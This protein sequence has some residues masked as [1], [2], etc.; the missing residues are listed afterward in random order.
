[1]EGVKNYRGKEEE[2]S[3]IDIQ[4]QPITRH[5]ETNARDARVQPLQSLLLRL[6][7]GGFWQERKNWMSSALR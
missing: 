5:T 6:R 3:F 4:L 2:F 7:T 1:M